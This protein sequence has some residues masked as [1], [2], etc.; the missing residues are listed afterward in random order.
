MV[1]PPLMIS[2]VMP[3]RDEAG[4]IATTLAQLLGQNYPAD[5]FEV[6]V[7]DG[8]SEDDT[9]RIVRDIMTSNANVRLLNNPLGRSSAGRNVGFR[10]GRGDVFLV[11]D[12]HCHISTPSLLQEVSRCF[13]ESGADCL[14]RPQHL[15]PPGITD[16][17]QAVALARSSWLGHGGGSLIY[18]QAEGFA[19]PVS[20]GAAYRRDVFERVGYVD[21]NFDACEDVE[22]NWRVEE[23]GLTCFTSPRLMVRYYPRKSIATLWRQMVR[24]GDGRYRL[25]KKHPATL[26]LST[27][28]PPLFVLGMTVSAL[29]WMIA[30]LAGLNA[31]GWVAAAAP[32]LYALVVTCESL[33]IGARS[34]LSTLVALP[35]IFATIHAGLGYGFLYAAFN[36]WRIGRTAS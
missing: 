14:G 34:R 29:V 7:C 31:L 25:F 6:L 23:A 3:V 11:I 15:D 5:R 26:S 4:Y 18:G 13:Q 12:G 21:E 27:L 28:V 9:P 35:A 10:Q 33:R 1:D 22:F 32:L 24:Y 8:M 36:T 20:N 16:F 19:S 30:S 17:Q 2:V